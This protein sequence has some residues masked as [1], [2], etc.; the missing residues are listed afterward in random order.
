[1]YSRDPT[2]TEMQPRDLM[3]TESLI[4]T[5]AIAGDSML[6]TLRDGDW[7]LVRRTQRLRR[8][9]IVAVRDPRVMDRIL[10]KRIVD[11]RLSGWWVLGDNPDGSTDSRSFGSIPTELVLGRVLARYYPLP[12]RWFGLF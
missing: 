12:L 3:Q 9:Q 5:A 2:L 7:V 4:F 10:V 1:M 8:G 11:Q 6:P